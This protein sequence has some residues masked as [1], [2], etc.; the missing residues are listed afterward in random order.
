[1][2]IRLILSFSILLSSGIAPLFSTQHQ[3]KFSEPTSYLSKSE[4]QYSHHLEDIVFKTSFSGL[5]KG[6]YPAEGENIE[7]ES[8]NNSSRKHFESGEELAVLFFDYLRGEFAA[9]SLKGLPFCKHI[10]H[11]ISNRW[12]LYIQVFLI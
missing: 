6:V 8:E 4:S 7:E 1:M 5:K 3:E 11:I 10:S 9:T 2:L 12:H